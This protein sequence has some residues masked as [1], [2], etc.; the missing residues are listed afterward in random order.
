[1]RPHW[2]DVAVFIV[3]A[4]DDEVA[5]R[6]AEGLMNRHEVVFIYPGP[7][8]YRARLEKLD[9]QVM[10]G[11]M[12]SRSTLQNAGVQDADYFI[13]CTDYDEQNIVACLT[14]QRLG[15]KSSV[16]FITHPGLFGEDHDDL[17]EALGIDHVVRPPGQLAEEIQRIVTVP[18]ALDVR[19]YY[20]G[21]VSLLKAE[22]EPG[23][24]LAE[25]RVRDA[26]IPKGV[27]MVLGRR[28]EEFLIPR[29]DTQ[30]QPGDRVTVIGQRGAIARFQAKH[31]RG[32]SS[33]KTARRAAV[34]GCGEVGMQLIRAL[35]DSGWSV[36]VIEKD[37]GR[38]ENAAEVLRRSGSIAIHGDGS[39]LELLEDEQ[40][41][42]YPVL[43]AVTNNDEKNLLISLLAKHL[44]IP[45]IVTRADNLTN[46]LLFERVGI[47]V[48]LSAKGAAVRTVLR[49]IEGVETHAFELE[50]GDVHVL[51]FELPGEYEPIRLDRL[52]AP[53]F[54]VVGAVTRKGRVII[55][56]G[57]T[58]LRP[59]DRILVFCLQ[60]DSEQSRN[61]FLDPQAYLD[62]VEGEA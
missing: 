47:D 55:P 14:A 52:R 4:G 25:S 56:K 50:H 33:S 43:V 42:A 38:V 19:Q 32:D 27:V 62:R 2:E 17:A 3:I 45:R 58:E 23:S 48:V 60:G 1:M 35:E 41:S 40:I 20:G 24:I 11:P 12:S 51:E 8:V 29:G 37:R 31:L 36:T 57:D 16:C 9:V 46:E 61:F 49:H 53:V 44:G 7:E 59:N 6:I 15:V 5:I 28:G 26:K 10:H 21:R 39:D 13:A 22:V 18:G 54:A 30:F 34:I